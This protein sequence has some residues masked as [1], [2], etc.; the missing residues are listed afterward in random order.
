[1]F[2]RSRAVASS[3]MNLPWLRGMLHTCPSTVLHVY[4]MNMKF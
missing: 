4:E 1:V 2:V 3:T